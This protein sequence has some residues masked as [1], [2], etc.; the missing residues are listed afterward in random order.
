MPVSVTCMG[1][2]SFTKINIIVCVCGGGYFGIFSLSTF[3]K[4]IPLIS[5]RDL[6]KTEL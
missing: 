4:Q 2:I 6:G 1:K 3:W 5:S